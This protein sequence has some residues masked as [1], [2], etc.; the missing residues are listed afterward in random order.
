MLSKNHI[1]IKQTTTNKQTPQPKILV[2]PLLLQARARGRV[3]LCVC[4]RRVG[5]GTYI[6]IYV[7]IILGHITTP[8]RRFINNHLSNSKFRFGRFSRAKLNLY[9]PTAYRFSSHAISR[10]ARPSAT[11]N[12]DTAS[13]FLSF[14][15]PPP[16]SPFQRTAM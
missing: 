8:N 12:I 2:L 14:L 7:Y 16:P 5:S 6:Y 3:C 4:A 13:S 15:C 10:D 9:E 11:L 1:Y